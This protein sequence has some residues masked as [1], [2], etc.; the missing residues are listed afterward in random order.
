[1]KKN[2]PPRMAQ[3]VEW[4]YDHLTGKPVLKFL[5]KELMKEILLQASGVRTR[6]LRITSKNKFHLD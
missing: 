1:M 2:K 3:A 6:S 5:D 4:D